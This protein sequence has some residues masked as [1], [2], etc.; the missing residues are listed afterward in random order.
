[1][2]KLIGLCIGLWFIPVSLFGQHGYTLSGLVKDENDQSLPG[3]SVLLLPDQK[4][5]VADVNGKFFIRNLPVGTYEVEISYLGYNTYKE[6]I[7]IDKDQDLHINLRHMLQT[8]QEVV[9]TDNYVENYKNEEPLN[10]EIVNE[11]YIKQNLGGSLMKSLER[12]PGVSTIDIGSG[13]SKPVIRGL[14]FN[15]VVVVENGIKHEGQ[16]W[17]ADHGLE[18]DQFSS[19]RIEVVKGPSSLIYGSDAIGGVINISQ[20]KALPKNTVGGT[21]DLVGK[22]NNNLL[23]TSA[24]AFAR[25]NHLYFTVRGTI[26]DYG[27]YRVPTDSIDIYSYRAPLQDQYLRNTAGKEKNI[28]FSLGWNNERFINKLF[29]SNLNSKSGFFANTHG[30]EPRQVDTDLHDASN[31][32]INYPFQQVNHVKL[33]NKSELNWENLGI[34]SELGF[35]RNYR[36]EWSQYVDHGYMPPVFPDTLPFDTDLERQFDKYIYS[37]NLMALYNIHNRSKIIGGINAKYQ[38]NSIDGRGFIIPDFR[39]FVI[40]AFGLIKHTFTQVY[41]QVEW[42]CIVVIPH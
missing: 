1:M 18:I 36:Q 9:V 28:H 35:Q 19:D 20:A 25:K 13:Q 23:G 29:F 34:E 31:R 5:T 33:I 17:G 4:G 38:D 8:L 21:I 37:A 22:S 24:Y 14:G 41:L 15:R 27:D 10:I 40:G 7:L 12:L 26:M 3:A 2:K 30:L 11:D 16:Q 42:F 32:D 39:Q 6:T